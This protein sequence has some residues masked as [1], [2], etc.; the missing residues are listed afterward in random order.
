MVRIDMIAEIHLIHT[1]WRSD[2]NWEKARIWFDS[3]WRNALDNL[4]NKVNK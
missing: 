3:V 4:K 2:G 1:G